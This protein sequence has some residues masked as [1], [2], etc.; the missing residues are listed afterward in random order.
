MGDEPDEHDLPAE[1]AL[2]AEIL[3]FPNKEFYP[4]FFDD[5]RQAK[6][7]LK[8]RLAVAPAPKAA[9]LVEPAMDA[10]RERAMDTALKVQL[11]LEYNWLRA[12]TANDNNP[13]DPPNV[14]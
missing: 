12:K 9:P 8:D 11:I 4:G 13:G 6:Q 1:V 14:A 2:A 10:L 7:M 3:E 5:F